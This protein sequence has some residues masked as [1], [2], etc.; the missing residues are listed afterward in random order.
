MGSYADE[1][2]K[3]LRKDGPKAHRKGEKVFARILP[4]LEKRK[5]SGYVAINIRTGKYITASNEVE[6]MRRYKRAFGDTLGWVRAF[7]VKK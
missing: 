7:Y 4:E 1:I 5:R 3:Q 2:R 6:L